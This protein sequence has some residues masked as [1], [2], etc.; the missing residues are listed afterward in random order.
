MNEDYLISLYQNIQT[1]LQSIE[2]MF[3][4]IEDESLKKTMAE[5]EKGYKEYENKCLELAKKK[6]LNLKDNNLF[7]KIRL[8]TSIQMGTMTDK[9]TRHLAEMFLLGTVMGTLTI[10]KDLHD[11]KNA[12][13]EISSL[14]TSLLN[15]EE[16]FFNDIKKHL[17][18]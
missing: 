12:D 4:K 15:L 9:S 6:N 10:Y 14:A 1:A 3:P 8:W 18:D 7:E 2:N 17:K 13:N 11:Y 5:Q 16:M